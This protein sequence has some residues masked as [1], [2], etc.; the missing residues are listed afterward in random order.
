M[1]CTKEAQ[2][3]EKGKLQESCKATKTKIDNKYGYNI[4]KA[5]EIF[6]KLFGIGQ[7]KLLEITSYLS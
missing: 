3:K 5:D 7:L 4:I 6:N 2:G 1:S